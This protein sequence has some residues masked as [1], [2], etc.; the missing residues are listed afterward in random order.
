MT[1]DRDTTTRVVRSWL[2]TEEYESAE[3]LLDAVLDRIDTTPQ[4]RAGWPAWSTPTMNRFA[5]IALGAAAVVA[6]ILVGS[7]L[8]G[9]PNGG[10][11]G[12]PTA[13]PEAS[14]ADPTPEPAPS[15]SVWTGIPEGPVVVTNTAT[16]PVQVTVDI[17]S[18]GW[19]PLADLD[20]VT[21]DDD[22]LDPPE[23]VGAAFLAWAWPAGTEFNVYG[24]PCQWS[25][26]IPEAPATTPDEI[27]AALATQ[28]EADATAPVDVTVG[29]YAGK[30]ITLH[31][32]LSYDLPNA[33]R[34]EK[35]ADCDESLYVFY[36]V[37]DDVEAGRNAQ[38]GGQIDDL[39]ILDVDGSIVILDAAYSP[40]TP[41][42]LVEELRSMA[43]SATFEAP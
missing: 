32:P 14:V 37:G 19:F 15:S 13:T 9:S 5:T 21:K 41:A 12:Q 35:F 22:G 38:G 25:R 42:D 4:R 36:G 2:R 11:G 29:G 24:D 16:S 23:S 30:A 40:A 33:S 3:R 18:P 8:L 10:L 34:D 1:T 7:Q 28:A 31:V 6:V 26:T 39:W 17:A 20:A 43:E 27:A